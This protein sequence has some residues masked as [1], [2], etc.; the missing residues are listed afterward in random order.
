MSRPNVA[1][2]FRAAGFTPEYSPWGFGMVWLRRLPNGQRVTVQHGHGHLHGDPE[3]DGWSNALF[4]ADGWIQIRGA[5][6]MTLAEAI[7][8][9]QG[10]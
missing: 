4:S 1:V 3:S 10:E 8:G 5:C 9:E 2:T 6:G 7:E